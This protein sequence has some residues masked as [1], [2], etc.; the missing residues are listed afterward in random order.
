MSRTPLPTPPTSRRLH[1][2][3][4]LL[5]NADLGGKV[6]GRRY[7]QQ[8]ACQRVAREAQ[9]ISLGREDLPPAL[10]WDLQ[11]MGSRQLLIRA[12]GLE[13]VAK[14]TVLKRILLPLSSD[15]TQKAVL[16]HF[17]YPASL[18]KALSP[19]MIGSSFQ[20]WDEATHP[21]SLLLTWELL[22]D[23]KA[24]PQGMSAPTPKSCSPLHSMS[25]HPTSSCT[26]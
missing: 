5:W 16:S 14:E 15:S 13:A 1:P 12:S 17:C 7:P 10:P 19:W 2:Y 3:A 9:P 26:P 8:K 18:P 23:N 22:R 21:L 6:K 20:P 25:G 24:S 11:A 4:N